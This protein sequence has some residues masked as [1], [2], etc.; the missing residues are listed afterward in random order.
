MYF[1]WAAVYRLQH[2]P[3]SLALTHVTYILLENKILFT[4]KENI[5]ITTWFGLSLKLKP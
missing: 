1:E 2:T 5:D 4:Q 3:N